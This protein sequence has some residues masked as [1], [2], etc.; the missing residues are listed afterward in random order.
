MK[1]API[2]NTIANGISIRSHTISLASDWLT[3]LQCNPTFIRFNGK[4]RFSARLPACFN[5]KAPMRTLLLFLSLLIVPAARA[6]NF[7]PHDGDRVALIGD[8]LIEREQESGWLESVMDASFPDRHFIVRNLGWS[9]DT[10]AGTSRA[11]FDFAEPEKGFKLLTDEVALVRPSVVILGYGM[12]SSFAGQ[13]GVAQFKTDMDRLIDTIQGQAP[14]RVR[15]VIFSPLRHWK[16]PPPLADPAAHNAALSQYT[17]ALRE[18]AQARGF[19]FVDLFDWQPATRARDLTDNGIHLTPQGYRLMALETARQ[20]GWPLRPKAV[21]EKT[22][23]PLRQEIVRKNQLFFDRWRPENQTYLFGFRQNEQG[24]NARE[25]PEFDPLIDAAEQRIFQWQQFLGAKAKQPPAPATVS[26]PA[27]ASLAPPMPEFDIAP[28][29]EISLWA[30]SPLLSKPTQIN[31]DPRGRLWVATSSIYPQITPGQKA[32]D[33]IVILDDTRHAGRADSSTIFADGLFVPTGVEPG[34]GGCYVGQS[35]ELLHFSGVAKAEARRV[36][37]S[38]FGTEDTHHIVHTLAWGPDGMLYFDQSIYIHSHLETPNGVVRLNSGGVFHLRPQSMQLDVFLRGFFNPWGHQFD[39]FGQSF[40]TDGAGYQG[41]S[42]G[43]PGATYMAYAGVRREL[44]SIS[45]GSY[46]KFC[47]LAIVAS[48]QFPDDWQ[49]NMLTADFR[50]HRLVRFS[51]S[52]DGAGYAS[53]QMPDFLRT[54]NETFRPIDLKFG[55]DGALY[56]ADWCNPIIN[57]G[58]VDFRDPR[59][60]HDHGRIWRITAKGRLLETRRD[61]T[62]AGNRALLD[63]LLSSNSF[64][65]KQS[66]RV[67]TERGQRILTDLGKWT[68]RQTNETALLQSLWMYQSLDVHNDLLLDRLLAGRDG[69]IRAAAARV[70]AAWPR[71]HI[72]AGGLEPDDVYERLLRDPFPRVRVEALRTVGGVPTLLSANWALNTLNQGTDPFL[73]YALWLTIN[74]LAKPWLEGVRSGAWNSAGRENQL[75]FALKAIEPDLAGPVLDELLRKQPLSDDGRGPWIELIGQTGTTGAVQQVYDAILNRALTPAAARR[76]WLALVEAAARHVQPTAQTEK[77]AGFFDGGDEE[78]R[79]DAA[80]L[81]GSWKVS[82]CFSNLCSLA[83]NSGVTPSVRKV[84]MDSLRNI[85]GADVI[86]TLQLWTGHGEPMEL[87][88]PAV[89]ALAAL[90]SSQGGPPALA[91]LLDLTNQQTELRVWRSLLGNSGAG[92]VLAATLPKSGFPPGLAKTGIRAVHESGG[93]QPE[94]VVALTRAAGLSGSETELSKGELMKLAE[95]VLNGGDPVRGERIYRSQ[96]QSCVTCHAIGGVG[97]HV[98]PDLTSLGASAQVDY[99]I[100][101]V[102]YPNKEIK[103]GFHS[104]LV[105]TRDGEEMAGIPLREDDRELVLRTAAD[106]DVTI[107]KSQILTR[108]VGGSLMPSGLTDNLSMGQQLD[109]FRFLSELGKPGPFDASSGHVARFWKVAPW[110]SDGVSPASVMTGDR[111]KAVPSLVDGK[112]LREDIEN[113]IQSAGPAIMAGARFQTAKA[114]PVHFN[115]AAPEAGDATAWLDG[116]ETI[117]HSSTVVELPAGMHEVILKFEAAKLPASI[118]LQSGDV[119]FLTN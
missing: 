86:A 98:G 69:R 41:I 56:V 110:E 11:S 72:D 81:A 77:L 113:R 4:S 21:N 63:N 51:V 26:P 91:L 99:L 29:F 94:L 66:R 55:P 46:P 53:E 93:R 101:S 92:E 35:T 85:G 48:R 95:S 38:G 10:P 59:R 52:P 119:T 47:G 31:F 32:N 68:A 37:L 89:L 28:G 100:E 96:Q 5:P 6:E 54:T 43:I 74:D 2:P 88:Q 112:L 16:L 30:A 50:A 76:A 9:A 62:L 15:F 19:P 82:G 24:K 60:D 45:P 67:L 64:D 108:K 106:Q 80:R 27:K 34:D 118:L 42:W 17:Q 23:E 58:E 73:D 65:V 20:L 117:L 102:Y 36:V 104:C 83:T 79:M 40:V 61:L 12:A 1:N 14:G 78:T 116:K 90:D 57:H 103:D 25:I 109:L 22:L 71:T 115:L 8:T 39:A 111:W 49:G 18:I 75:A 3:L 105:E 33:K 84:A 7:D 107:A 97:G 114:G 87:R 13:A 70:L 44:A